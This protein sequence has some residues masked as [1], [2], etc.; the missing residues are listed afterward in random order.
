MATNLV[1]GLSFV[2]DG[3]SAEA[4]AKVV[5]RSLAEIKKAA[6]DTRDNASFDTQALAASFK[7]LS[8]IKGPTD[9]AIRQLG[10]FNTMVKSLSRLTGPNTEMVNRLSAFFS[11]LGGLK[12][13]NINNIARLST[14]A[15]RPT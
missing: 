13:P 8:D 14:L 7:R 12:V 6:R 1:G 2:I 10:A 5:V 9:Q 15:M 11:V 3:S 4:G